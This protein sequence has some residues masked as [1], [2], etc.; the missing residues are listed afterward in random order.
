MWELLDPEAGTAV[1]AGECGSLEGGPASVFCLGKVQVP[2]PWACTC[3][4]TQP[5]PVPQGCAA[6]RGTQWALGHS[7]R[8]RPAAGPHCWPASWRL[9]QVGL[10]VMTQSWWPACGHGQLR[11]WWTMSGAC[12]LRKASSASPFVPVVVGDFLSDTPEALI[13]AE[14]SMACR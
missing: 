6:E 5:R 10:V 4:P 8:R 12:C 9:S 3:C 7:G 14:T 1:G 13:N 11:T 2:P